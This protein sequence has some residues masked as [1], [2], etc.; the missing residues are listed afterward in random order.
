VIVGAPV[1]A[2]GQELFGELALHPGF[3]EPDKLSDAV[4]CLTLAFSVAA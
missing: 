1:S 3:V 4:A 2:G